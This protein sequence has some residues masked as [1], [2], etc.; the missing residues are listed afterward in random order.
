V[1]D[2]KDKK[3]CHEEHLCKL[4]KREELEQVRKLVKDAVFFCNKCGRVAREQ[5]NLCD[6]S[7]I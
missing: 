6:P 5:G 1:G 2:C 3:R 4:V 7:R